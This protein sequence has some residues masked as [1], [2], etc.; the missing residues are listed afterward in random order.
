MTLIAFCAPLI[1]M[2]EAGVFEELISN[3]KGV[4]ADWAVH[5]TPFCFL[6]LFKILFQEEGKLY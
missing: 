3:F 1:E 6:R 4:G 5:N 2:L